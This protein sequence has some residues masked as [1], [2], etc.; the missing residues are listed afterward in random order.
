MLTFARFKMNEQKNHGGGVR[1]E[2]K[3]GKGDDL[4]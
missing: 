4:W 1:A 2:E 3:R